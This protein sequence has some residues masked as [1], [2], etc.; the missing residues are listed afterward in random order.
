M[1]LASEATTEGRRANA[2]KNSRRPS[3]T[4]PNILA[5]LFGYDLK[6]VKD[7]QVLITNPFLSQ[8]PND[9]FYVSD[10]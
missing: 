3:P 4:Q 6:I 1:F 9:L 2:G 10:L 5:K 7:K 8:D